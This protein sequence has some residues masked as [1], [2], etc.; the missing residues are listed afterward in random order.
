MGFLKRVAFCV[1]LLLGL[2]TIAAAG[3]VAMVYLFT[4]KFPSVE[5]AEGKPEVTLLTPDEVAAMVRSQ[6]DKAKAAAR[7]AEMAGG[8]EHDAA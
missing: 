1:G 4:G 2:T 5:V 3:T 8:E 6:V 7:P